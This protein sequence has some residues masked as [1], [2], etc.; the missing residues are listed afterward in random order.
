LL[1]KLFV[2]SGFVIALINQADQLHPQALDLAARYEGRPLV[3]TDA[4]LLEIGNALARSYRQEA[5]AVIESFLTADHVEV[6][7]LTPERF[8]RA[9]ARYKTHRDKEWS[10]V[11]CISFEVM[12]QRGIRAALAFDRHFIQ[13]GFEALLRG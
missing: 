5:V 7:G 12:E 3:V 1:P 13:A 8:A 4:V 11:D 6:V 10:L 2:D 9:L